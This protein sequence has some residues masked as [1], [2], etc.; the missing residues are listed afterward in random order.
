MSDFAPT[1]HDYPNFDP[2]SD[3][4]ALRKAMKG[5]G[6]D[7]KTIV[8]VLGKRSNKQRQQIIV[9]YKMLYGKDL[10]NDLKG[11]LSGK[12][13]AVIIALLVP[14]YEYDA[15]LLRGSIRGLGTDE[16]LLIEILSS[17]SPSD[18]RQIKQVYQQLFKKD[19]EKDIINDTSGHFQRL[20]V[21][22]STGM[23]DEGNNIDPSLAKRDAEA[24]LKA[25]VKKWGTDE[26]AFNAILASRNFN[27]L[28]ATMDEYR[29]ISGHT[30][31]QAIRSE[32]SGDL[33]NAMTAVAKCAQYRPAYFAE[34]LYN[35]MKGIGTNDDM[36]IRIVVTRCEVDMQ[37]IKSEFQR[38]YGKS[39]E[40]FISGD[41]SGDYK[42]V[43]IALVQGNF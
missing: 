39:L 13:E 1:I 5:L 40:S 20:L 25:G 3:A 11:E 10:I 22:L 43:L 34:R 26:S 27:Q 6:T 7:E 35:S 24:L 41:C 31:E 30:L 17:R 4:E 2:R 37:N 21:S 18:I 28:R 38:L 19:L 12:F 8:N 14:T 9:Q 15:R 33:A 29:K 32:M 42:R 23:R 36:L 16:D